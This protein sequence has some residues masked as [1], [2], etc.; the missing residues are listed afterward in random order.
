MEPRITKCY[1]FCLVCRLY[2]LRLTRGF[3]IL[4]RRV[5][6]TSFVT[7]RCPCRTLNR[8]PPPTACAPCQHCLECHYLSSRAKAGPRWL[9][10]LLS[11]CAAHDTPRSV[12]VS[13]ASPVL[14]G[15][16]AATCFQSCPAAF[17][18]PSPGQSPALEPLRIN[19]MVKRT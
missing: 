16:C 8:W 10:L 19:L 7:L 11:V 13:A 17:I 9:C 12:A 3:C 14:A 1:W 6:P 5:T 2:S 15:R 4:L 18:E